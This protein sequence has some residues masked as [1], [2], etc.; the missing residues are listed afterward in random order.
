[1]KQA[2]EAA[3]RVAMVAAERVERDK[4]APAMLNRPLKGEVGRGDVL[5]TFPRLL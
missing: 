5:H 3:E 1:M 4:K 2:A